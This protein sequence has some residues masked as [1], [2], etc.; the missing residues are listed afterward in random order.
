MGARVPMSQNRHNL[1]DRQQQAL[2]WMVRVGKASE[3]LVRERGFS[4]RTL[5]ALVEAGLIERRLSAG[6][7]RKP[8]Y[9]LP[10]TR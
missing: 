2:T 3:K 4:T 1:T 8:F 5:D 6:V 10:N 9:C 7:L